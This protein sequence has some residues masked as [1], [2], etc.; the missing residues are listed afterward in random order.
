M[1][2]FSNQLIRMES[3]LYKLNDWNSNACESIRLGMDVDV[4][5]FF[6][7]TYF[8]R[9]GFSVEKVP[10]ILGVTRNSILQ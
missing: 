6:H 5:Y 8:A 2:S 4:Q 9:L 7:R 1:L 3:D 10:P